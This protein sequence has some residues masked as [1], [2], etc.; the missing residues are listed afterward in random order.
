MRVYF[1]DPFSDIASH[2]LLIP[3]TIYSVTHGLLLLSSYPLKNKITH[4]YH[5]NT[6]TLST[7]G[8]L[9]AEVT[10]VLVSAV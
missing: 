6:V 8:Y 7:Q 1:V 9:A 3:N 4:T 2:C 5:P 10:L